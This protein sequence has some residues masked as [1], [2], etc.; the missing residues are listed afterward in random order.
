MTPETSEDRV[1]IYKGH[2]QIL[3]KTYKSGSEEFIV[4]E[5][6]INYVR[7]NTDKTMVSDQVQKAIEKR[8]AGYP[9]KIE[10]NFHRV[11][12]YVPVAVAALL[13]AEPSLIAPAVRAFYE[14]DLLDIKVSFKAH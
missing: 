5:E 4:T 1:F 8:I 12:L 3:P 2:V 9:K 13:N 14:R 11:N 10:E 7:Q 6:V